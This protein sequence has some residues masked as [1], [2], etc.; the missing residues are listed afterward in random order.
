MKIFLPAL[1]LFAFAGT[2]PLCAARV[3]AV[4]DSLFKKAEL[5]PSAPSAEQPYALNV[6]YFLPAGTDP[7]PNYEKRLS[8]ILLALQ[9]FYLNEMERN[10]YPKRTFGLNK[11]ADGKKVAIEV[12]RGKG[13][14]EMYGYDGGGIRAMLEINEF[15]EANPDKKFSEHA[16]VI[17]PSVSGNPTEP[18]GVPF[19]GL[20]KFCFA[21]DYPEF[22]MKHCGKEGK[23]GALFTK[24]F[25]GMGHEL[26]HGLNLPHT[27][28]TK[29]QE[30]NFGTA[31][32]GSGNYSLGRSPT[33][34][35]PA[36]CAILERCQVFRTKKVGK[37]PCPHIDSLEETAIR[38]GDFGVRVSGKLPPKNRVSAVLVY[39]D[40]DDCEA[41]NEDYDA[42]SFV[43]DFDREQNTFT[44]EIP[45]AEIHPGNTPQVQIRVRLIYADG[46]CSIIRHTFPDEVKN[47]LF[48]PADT[49]LK[50]LKPPAK[51]KGWRPEKKSHSRNRKK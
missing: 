9:R 1:F 41:V 15:F 34:L 27:R 40:K 49:L 37:N 23:L 18:G 31:L 13:S 36:S 19:Y 2:L 22:D 48:V 12:V 7:F 10:G 14:P 24:W 33:F 42:E 5:P 38:F 44:V 32:M 43:A 8:E 21:L 17:M 30:E 29:T 16:L 11:S 45:Y 51:P 4:K 39:Y 25:G 3:P 47:D 6:V 20:G 26:E 28:G 50:E 46:T 35:T